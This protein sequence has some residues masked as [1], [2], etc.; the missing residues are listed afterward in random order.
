VHGDG[1]AEDAAEVGGERQVA[2]LVELRGIES[3]RDDGARTASHPL[4][5]PLDGGHGV[6]D[7]FDFIRHVRVIAVGAARLVEIA[8]GRG[9]RDVRAFVCADGASQWVRAD[10]PGQPA[11]ETRAFHLVRCFGARGVIRS[12]WA[13]SSR[14]DA[15]RFSRERLEITLGA[16]RHVHQ[17]T[18]RHWGMELTVAG[19]RSGI[20]LTGWVV[21]APASSDDDGTQAQ[22]GQPSPGRPPIRL[23][24]STPV[25]FELGAPHYRRSEETWE[26]AGRPEVAADQFWYKAQ[27][28]ILG[29]E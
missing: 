14:V 5:D 15:V 29:I 19:A 11:S 16:E 28:E 23:R 18:D 17:L 1:L 3:A 13:W 12:V 10:A 24:R 6:E 21:A 22:A 27:A 2:A 20:E 26:Q 7:G 4:G 9:G 8:G 25:V